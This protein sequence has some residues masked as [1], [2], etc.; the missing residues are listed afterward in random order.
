MAVARQPLHPPP[1]RGPYAAHSVV[2]EMEEKILNSLRR[3]KLNTE[4][5]MNR[6]SLTVQ[7]SRVGNTKKE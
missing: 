7:S 2:P 3:F 5:K 6:I 4:K 1:A